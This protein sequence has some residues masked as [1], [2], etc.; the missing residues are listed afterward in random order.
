M[1]DR[2]KSE[3]MLHSKFKIKTAIELPLQHRQQGQE[4]IEYQGES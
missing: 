2:R 1:P 3:T 4:T